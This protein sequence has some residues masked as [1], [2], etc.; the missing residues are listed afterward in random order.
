MLGHKVNAAIKSLH[1]KFTYHESEAYALSIYLS[2]FAIEKFE[3]LVF[4]FLFN[5]LAVVYYWYS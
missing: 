2:R 3:K 5:S 1:D 4:V